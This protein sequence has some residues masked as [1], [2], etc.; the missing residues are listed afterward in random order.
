MEEQKQFEGLTM[1]VF[2]AFGWAGEDAALQ[3]AI[4]QLTQFGSL[5][6]QMLPRDAQLLLP[7][8]GLDQESQ[9]AYLATDEVITDGVHVTFRA[10]PMNF[11]ISAAVMNKD[12]L[13][14]SWKAMEA[15]IAKLQ[16]AVSALDPEWTIR[17]EEAQ[18]DAG[19]K[20]KTHYT[21][22]FNESVTAFN[23]EA[24]ESAVSRGVY[25]NGDK[26]WI[27]PIYL[28]MS[29][30]SERASAMGLGIIDEMAKIINRLMPI[31][32][33][34]A[35]PQKAKQAQKSAVA[36]EKKA[37]KT[38]DGAAPTKTRK[39]SVKL[40]DEFAYESTLKKL[41]IRRGFVNL[42]SEHW[43]FFGKTARAETR[44]VILH[45]NDIEDTKSAVWRLVPDDQARIMLSGAVQLW[46][47]NN[48][49]PN[50]K[51]KIVGKKYSNAEIHL[52]LETA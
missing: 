26:E 38:A 24:A 36:E 27:A 34:W 17:V 52:Y 31:L 3:Y 30:P 6:H 40:N 46:V 12:A 20:Q 50:S 11:N 22:A 19:T 25:R 45:Y 42:T 41:H 13:A 1:P 48:F 23:K 44:D 51:M 29:L 5:L 2:T 39:K 7:A 8:N 14:V 10:T 32:N 28:N 4:D 33:I 35:G 15:D 37:A 21:D 16:T 49:A 18:Y 43:P 9:S 47:E